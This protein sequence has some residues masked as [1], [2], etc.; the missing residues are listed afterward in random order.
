[1]SMND[2]NITSWKSGYRGNDAM[3]NNAEKMF[4][5]DIRA[6]KANPPESMSSPGH[7]NLRKFADGGG[8]KKALGGQGRDS[9]AVS[10]LSTP[11]GYASHTKG[12]AAGGGIKTAYNKGGA[13]ES[14]MRGEKPVGAKTGGCMKRGGHHRKAQGGEAKMGWGGDLLGKLGLPQSGTLG[15]LAGSFAKQYP[16]MTSDAGRI[17]STVGDSLGGIRYAKGGRGRKAGGTAQFAKGGHAQHTHH[18]LTKEM[19]NLH[20]PKHKSS[21]PIK[22]EKFFTAANAKKGGHMHG[23]GR[24]Y[25]LGGDVPPLGNR[26]SAGAQPQATSTPNAA[27]DY[28]GN[29]GQQAPAIRAQRP[30]STSTLAQTMKKGGGCKKK[31]DGGGVKKAWGGVPDNTSY[32]GVRGPSAEEWERMK[33]GKPRTEPAVVRSYQ[34]GPSKMVGPQPSAQEQ[35]DF[36]KNLP[37]NR[38][39]YGAMRKGGEIN[40]HGHGKMSGEKACGHRHA[41]GG[42]AKGGE[43]KMGFGGNLL[44]DVMH[45]VGKS[46]GWE[47]AS[48]GPAK[49]K[50]GKAYAAGGVAKV[51]HHEA[52]KAGKPLHNNKSPKWNNLF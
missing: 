34:P 5:H 16:G 12:R 21:P 26:I 41:T 27:P 38:P 3:R 8:V 17:A 33:A 6:A 29:Q 19:S 43:A 13:Y 52:T 46:Q 49:A 45:S 14:N 47:K 35:A 20:I 2:D 30:F 7:T 9:W 36:V 51:R 39:T 24:K 10:P 48:G 32:N 15:D 40:K 1:M 25:D 28:S 22:T 31:A 50:G 37:G 11:E 42:K 44:G 23:K 18:A 4:G